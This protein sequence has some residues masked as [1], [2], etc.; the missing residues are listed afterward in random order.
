MV[1]NKPLITSKEVY[2]HFWIFSLCLREDRASYQG[3]LEVSGRRGDSTALRLF[4][5]FLVVILMCVWVDNQTNKG[6]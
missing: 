5:Y 1:C 3:S 4:D 2:K 6:I